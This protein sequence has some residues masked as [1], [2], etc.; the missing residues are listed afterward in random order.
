MPKDNIKYGTAAQ[1]GSAGGVL[2]MLGGL[3]GGKKENSPTPAKNKPKLGVKRKELPKSK[4]AMRRTEIPL[5]I[6]TIPTQKMPTGATPFKL[7]SG[8][9][10]PFKMMGSSP[11]KFGMFGG[12]FGRNRIAERQRKFWQKI[13]NKRGRSVF[14][15]DPEQQQAQHPGGG[16]G[17]HTHGTG[18]E[19]IGGTNVAAAAPAVPEAPAQPVDEEVVA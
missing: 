9:T 7:R 3:M 18:G 8:N 15:I 6:P 13:A 5:P 10:T 19:P 1:F 14:G 12:M 16:D 11:A 17:A 4:L 2:G